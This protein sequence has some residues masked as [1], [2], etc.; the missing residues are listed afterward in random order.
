MHLDMNVSLGP[1]N[2]V[3]N[4]DLPNLDPHDDGVQGCGGD[5]RETF[6]QGIQL[7]L[8]VTS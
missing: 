3:H 6:R 4:L 7:L 2:F 8:S 5:V 1:Q